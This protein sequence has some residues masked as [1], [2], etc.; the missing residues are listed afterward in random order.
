MTI[1]GKRNLYVKNYR[2]F[3]LTRMKNLPP[4]E[5]N[6]RPEE[7]SDMCSIENGDPIFLYLKKKELG[8]LN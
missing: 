6:E 2:E 8:K 1:L 4:C 3:E 5:C 7:D